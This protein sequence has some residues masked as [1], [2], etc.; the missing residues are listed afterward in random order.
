M[1]IADG[2]CW[3]DKNAIRDKQTGRSRQ[4]LYRLVFIQQAQSIINPSN[5][6]LLHPID[7][8]CFDGYSTVMAAP[9]AHCKK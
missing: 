1:M 2:V 7:C 3:L 8:I 5:N 9:T 4:S 6:N